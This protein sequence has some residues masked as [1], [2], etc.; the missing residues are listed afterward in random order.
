MRGA[1]T[2]RRE[3]WGDREVS[4]RAWREDREV[5]INERPAEND[6]GATGYRGRG[7]LPRNLSHGDASDD[8]LRGWYI[9]LYSGLLILALKSKPAYS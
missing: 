2:F 6:G 3:A 1:G 8:L 5:L 9:A 7:I 4:L